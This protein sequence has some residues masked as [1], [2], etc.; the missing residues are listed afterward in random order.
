MTLTD[1]Q[2]AIAQI[3]GHPVIGKGG[4]GARLGQARIIC[5]VIP[6]RPAGRAVN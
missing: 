6:S 5:E 4:K 1:L 3:A 2:P